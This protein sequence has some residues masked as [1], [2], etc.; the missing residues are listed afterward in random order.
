MYVLYEYKSAYGTK[1]HRLSNGKLNLSS[2]YSLLKIMENK[3]FVEG[4]KEDNQPIQAVNLPRVIY[5][6]TDKGIEIVEKY[7]ELHKLIEG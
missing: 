6:I 7:L 5:S 2:I 1:L 4:V 3:S